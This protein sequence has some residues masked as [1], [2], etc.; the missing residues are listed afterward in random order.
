M[1]FAVCVERTMRVF[2]KYH[3][4]VAIDLVLHNP[5]EME[6]FLPTVKY[7][8]ASETVPQQVRWQQQC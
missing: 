6:V 8:A 2:G 7:V 4:F 3:C 5:A 1:C